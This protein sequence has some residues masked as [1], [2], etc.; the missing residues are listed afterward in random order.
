M[1]RGGFLYKHRAV[2]PETAI[3]KQTVSIPKA[4]EKKVSEQKAETAKRAWKV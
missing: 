4:Y 1:R 2:L 3:R